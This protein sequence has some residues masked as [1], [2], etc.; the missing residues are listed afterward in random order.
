VVTYARCGLTKNFTDNPFSTRPVTSKSL[1]QITKGRCMLTDHGAFLLLNIYAPNAGRGS[2]HL[3]RK[4][5]FYNELS[6]AM[7]RWTKD[8]RN[9]IVTGDINTAHSE[10]DIYNPR[11]YT[12]ETGFLESEREWITTFLSER[13]CKDVWREFNPGVRKYTFW[14]Q[15]RRASCFRLLLTVVLREK[16]CGWRI[17]IFYAN[18]SMME[19]VI[20]SEILTEVNPS[21]RLFI[22]FFFVF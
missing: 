3:Q 2:E 20:G 17:D 5:E 22:I 19:H 14:D 9:V 6:A 13:K 15:K 18:E 16:N 11:K 7:G 21:P 4:M 1:D 12:L 10:L 8:G